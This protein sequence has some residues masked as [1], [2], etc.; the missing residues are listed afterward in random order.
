MEMQ[1]IVVCAE[2][3]HTVYNIY[4]QGKGKINITGDEDHFFY[5]LGWII[6]EQYPEIYGVLS[7]I[8]LRD[9]MRR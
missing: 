8:A 3:G 4:Q 5:I 1:D 9:F 7:S 6:S 2:V